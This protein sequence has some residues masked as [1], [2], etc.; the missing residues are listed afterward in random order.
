[1]PSLEFTDTLVSS[2]MLRKASVL[3]R[4]LGRGSEAD[5]TLAFSRELRS[6][7]RERLLD[8]STMTFDNGGESAQALAIY[9][10]LYDDENERR[11][12]FEVLLREIKSRGSF[13]TVGILG[14]KGIFRVLAEEDRKSVV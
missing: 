9:H 10:R 3:L 2:D 11:T 13:M 4:A 6:A 14:Q 1:M 5:F 12:A 7:I 8:K